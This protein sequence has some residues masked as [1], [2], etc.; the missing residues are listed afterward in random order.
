MY[1]EPPATGNWYNFSG[2]HKYPLKYL[3]DM[4]SALAGPLV[5]YYKTPYSGASTGW[6]VPQMEVATFSGY[7]NNFGFFT[8]RPVSS[9]VDFK[10]KSSLRTVA[11]LLTENTQGSADG[12]IPALANTNVVTKLLAFL[13]K[14]GQYGSGVLP[15]YNDT[16]KTSSDYTQWSARRKIFYGLEQI[17]AR[18]KSSKS[19]EYTRGYSNVAYPDWFF[20]KG[21]NDVDADVTLDETIG[22][23]NIEKGLAVFVDYRDSSHPKYK[24]YNWNNFNKLVTG[25]G[26]LLSET[27]ATGGTYSI[28]ENIINVLD[29][30]LTGFAVT[31]GHLKAL[32]HTLGTQMYQYSLAGWSVTNGPKDLITNKLP[33]LLSTYDGR[34][35]ELLTVGANLLQENGWVEYVVKN[36]SSSWS[37]EAII[38]DLYGLLSHDALTDPGSSF[39]DGLCERLTYFHLRMTDG[40]PDNDIYIRGSMIGS[41]SSRSINYLYSSEFDPY[42]AL[43][44]ILSK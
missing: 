21:S 9:A 39:Y 1:Y 12:L 41:P 40:D 5:R 7:T 36:I 10:P 6:W 20:T 24:G 25:I 23:D 35:N 22:A 32:R 26:E 27:G 19:I 31:D 34:Y 43:G 16:D 37:W 2:N 11:N 18:V 42:G 13:Q 33:Y 4:I 28:T 17:M 8:P 29:K 15:I 3:G 44:E 38:N 30:S 14:T